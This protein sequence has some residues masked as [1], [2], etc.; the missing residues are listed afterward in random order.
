[1][2]PAVALHDLDRRLLVPATEAEPRNMGADL[3]ELS[4]GRLLLAYSRWLGG[5]HDFDD[6]QISAMI[7]ADGGD[8][9]SSPFDLA[10]P[11]P[12]VE[13]V[14]MPCFV[15]LAGGELACYARFRA[16][17]ADTWVGAILCRDETRLGA[18]ADDDPR[19]GPRLWTEPR[20]VT[21]PPPGRHVLLNN[22]AVTLRHGSRAGRILLPV[23]SPWP[24]DEADARGSD[25]RS[26][27][28]RSDD[29]GHTW[30]A[31]DSMLAGP[32]RGLMEPYIVELADGRLRMWMRTQM[33]C[34]Y[35][36]ISDDG[37]ATWTD[38]VP[39]PLLS[40]ESPVAV[41]RHQASGLLLIVWNHNRVGRHTADRTPICLAFSADEGESWFG[42]QRLDPESGSE[43]DS[44][45]FSYPSLH[46]FGDRGFVT[47]YENED[48]R[49][50]LALRRFTLKVG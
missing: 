24:W 38:A 9:W 16:S 43:A 13:A 23:A 46:L 7:S 18:T 36:S 33:D 44:R 35:E 14:R 25:V 50:G 6:S 19:H 34:Q 17:V 15:R 1:M 3:I 42:E 2:T 29:D 5:S 21:P 12:G 40:P 49:I 45:S 10:L 11:Q 41:A 32:K 37:G 8:S 22:R 28:L 20:R 4:D 26:W 27:V 47:Y 48:R 39:G 31:S 30:Q